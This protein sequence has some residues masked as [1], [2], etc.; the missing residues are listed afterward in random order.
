MSEHN[1]RGVYKVRRSVTNIKVITHHNSYGVEANN[2]DDSK[3]TEAPLYADIEGRGVNGPD[4]NVR[5]FLYHEKKNSI[6]S[7][8]SS[9]ARSDDRA[10]D[11]GGDD[12]GDEENKIKRDDRE[13]GVGEDDSGD[14][15]STQG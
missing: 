3:R 11:E 2:V 8:E 15:E 5:V 10:T 9:D 7:R 4:D 13:I 6:D 1:Y 12:S 14:E